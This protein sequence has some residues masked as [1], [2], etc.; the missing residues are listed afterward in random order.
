MS[1]PTS[2]SA[3]VQPTTLRSATRTANNL[4]SAVGQPTTTIQPREETEERKVPPAGG[5]PTSTNS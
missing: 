4:Q 5:T 2:T 1:N 3:T